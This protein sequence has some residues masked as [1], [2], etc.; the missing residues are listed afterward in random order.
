MA[1]ISI[2]DQ[3]AAISGGDR[4]SVAAFQY[5]LKIKRRRLAVTIEDQVAAIGDVD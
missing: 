5:R 4:R 2:E 3:K 1:S